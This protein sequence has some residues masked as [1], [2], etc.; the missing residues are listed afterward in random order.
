MV[1]DGHGETVEDGH[2]DADAERHP[3][4]QRREWRPRAAVL[5]FIPA[6]WTCFTGGLRGF[7]ALCSCY[8]LLQSKNGLSSY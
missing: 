1:E 8:S 4:L 3:V 5:P 6:G 7:H 2:G